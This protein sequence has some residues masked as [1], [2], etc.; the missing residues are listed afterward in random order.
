MHRLSATRKRR[1]T[2]VELPLT[3]HL[4]ELRSRIAWTVGSWFLCAAACYAWAEDIFS[5]LLAPALAALGE[6]ASLQSIA[7]TEIFFTYIKCALL[8]GFIFALPMFFWQ[9]WAFIAPGLYD[10]EK[11]FVIPFVASSS[12]LFTSGA[13]F[14]YSIVFPIIFDFFNSFSSD[15]VVSAWTMKEVFSLT[16]R[17]FLA[18]GIAFELPLLVFFLAMAGIVSAKQMLE[19]TPY[20]VL[21]V[22]LVAAILT[23]PDVVSQFFLAIP[24]LCLYLVGVGAAFFVGKKKEKDSKRSELTTDQ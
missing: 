21:V 12:L 9:V 2:D 7:P 6:Q 23:P 16:T 4:A 20:M 17:L 24:M 10:G 3:D 15:F 5:F 19:F 18:F 13:V 11:R 8:A 14:G 1:L 22:F